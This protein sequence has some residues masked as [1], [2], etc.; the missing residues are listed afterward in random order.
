RAAGPR[1]AGG[2]VVVGGQDR[3]DVLDLV[4]GERGGALGVGVGGQGLG[5]LV[6]GRPGRLGVEGGAQVERAGRPRGEA[7]ATGRLLAQGPLDDGV[8]L[9]LGDPEGGDAVVLVGPD[10]TLVEP[11]VAV[12]EV[13]PGVVPTG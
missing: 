1:S 9:G 4:E 11:G 7:A 10:T 13:E 12:V 6:A 8:H 5:D 3:L 2:D